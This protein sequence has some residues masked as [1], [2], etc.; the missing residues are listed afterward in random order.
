MSEDRG[1]NAGRGSIARLEEQAG[2]G[3]AREDRF[4]FWIQFKDQA[5]VIGAG[6]AELRRRIEARRAAA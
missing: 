2:I 3:P 4:A 6:V 5:D 1:F